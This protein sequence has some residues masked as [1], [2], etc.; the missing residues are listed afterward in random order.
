MGRGYLN[1]PKL[2]AKVFVADPF[3]SEPGS[4]MYLTGDIGR[5]LWSGEIEYAGRADGQVKVRGYRVELGEIEAQLRQWGRAED[6]A[7]AIQT[8]AGESRLVAYV[9]GDKHLK[10]ELKEYCKTHFPFYMVPNNYVFTTKWPLSG[11]GKLDLK[12]IPI[13]ADEDASEGVA[14]AT[15]TEELL[16]SIWAKLLGLSRIS[17]TDNFFELGGRRRLPLVRHTHVHARGLRGA[18]RVAG[19]GPRAINDI[20]EQVRG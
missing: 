3:A 8:V 17:V 9:L 7:V 16:V 10:A 12:A 18:L 14:A 6:V 1:A 13:D 19:C 15:P 5:W 20:T 4:R 11:N 2:T